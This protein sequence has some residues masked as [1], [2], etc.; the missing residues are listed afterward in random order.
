NIRA[1][2]YRAGRATSEPLRVFYR[3]DLTQLGQGRYVLAADE[4]SHPRTQPYV[5]D[6]TVEIVHRGK[7]YKFR[8]FY[9]HHKLLPPNQAIQQLANVTM[10]GDILVVACGTKVNV[11]NFRNRLEVRAAEKA[12]RRFAQHIT[13]FRARRRFPASAFL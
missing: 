8:L 6:S 10:D 13:P 4:L 3:K 12:V 9:K 7:R 11:R 2:I 1:R 5:H